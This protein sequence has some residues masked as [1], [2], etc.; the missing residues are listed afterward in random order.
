MMRLR[1]PYGDQEIARV[2][3]EALGDAERHFD[4]APALRAR[5]GGPET[6]FR[7]QGP[8][9]QRL[10]LWLGSKVAFASIIGIN[11]NL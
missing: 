5:R 10:G 7:D 2:S 8:L 9:R 4:S 1:A 6:E 11:R 3:S